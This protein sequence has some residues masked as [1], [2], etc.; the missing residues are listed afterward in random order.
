MWAKTRTKKTDRVIEEGGKETMSPSTNSRVIVEPI[1]YPDY[2]CNPN[3]G[4]PASAVISQGGGH[5]KA[6]LL[7][8]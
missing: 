2:L 7:N 1:K 3:R 5:F 8:I 6:R 4:P